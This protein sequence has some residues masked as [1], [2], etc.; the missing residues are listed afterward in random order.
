MLLSEKDFATFGTDPKNEMMT[1]E[2]IILQTIKFDLEVEHPHKYIIIYGKEIKCDKVVVQQLVQMAW[3]FANDSLCS[4]LCLQWE[5]EV[6]AMALMF[7]ASKINKI[8]IMGWIHENFDVTTEL[9]DDIC[10]Q[11]LDVYQH[12][13]KM[14][15]SP[16]PK[17]AVSVTA[18]ATS[19]HLPSIQVPPIVPPLP[20]ADVPIILPDM[21]VP[22]PSMM[23]SFTNN[24]F[25]PIT[26]SQWV[27]GGSNQ[28]QSFMQPPYA[29]FMSG[30]LTSY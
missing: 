14:K 21:S 12:T 9:L 28:F 1:L 22:P 26:N 24:Y 16:K 15:P 13:T 19:N 3:T 18:R 8:D 27:S 25:V 17:T 7:L 5:A 2:K 10:H 6:L 20:V 29:T 30:Q 11:V 4:T 23:P